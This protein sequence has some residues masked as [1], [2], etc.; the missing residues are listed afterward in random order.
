M[1]EPMI[2]KYY[3]GKYYT[4]KKNLTDEMMKK[5]TITEKPTR[6]RPKFMALKTH[7][8]FISM[9]KNVAIT[10]CVARSL[11]N[12][13]TLWKL[14]NVP[15]LRPTMSMQYALPP[16]R[17]DQVAIM[18]H[19]HDALMHPTSKHVF[20]LNM[21]TGFG[22][23]RIGVAMTMTLKLKTIIV[24]PTDAIAQQWIDDLKLVP[25]IR[26][27][28][29]HN[30]P[31]AGE[32]YND[33][34]VADLFDVIV[35]VINTFR[36]KDHKFSER[37]GFIIFDE[38]HE[39]HS[40][41]NVKALWN[42]GHKLALGLSASPEER[43]DGFDRA[44]FFHLGKPIDAKTI[45][46]FAAEESNFKVCV[47]AIKF[48]GKA[49]TQYT[50]SGMMS[51]PLTI[52]QLAMDDSRIDLIV[53]EIDR[54]QDMGVKGIFVFSELRSYL[55]KIKLRLPSAIL[56]DEAC[57]RIEPRAAIDPLS[58]LVLAPPILPMKNAQLD[59]E[60]GDPPPPPI[61]LLRG[62]IKSAE[63]RAAKDAGAH[64]VLTTY[65]YSR[66][67]VNLPTMTAIILATPRRNGMNQIIGRILR[68]GSDLSLM[69][70]VIDIVDVNVALA[71]Q[72]TT[73]KQF[74]KLRQ[75]PV[76]IVVDDGDH[77]EEEELSF[78]E[79]QELYIDLADDE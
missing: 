44:V 2:I 57:D 65:G 18:Q 1:A 13:P 28:Y 59:M 39:Y 46:G 21:Q 32:K 3:E 54:L 63:L 23:T 20:Y 61:S 38:A 14:T 33:L 75:Y 29:F 9:R 12:I 62:G 27:C 60:G 41:C 78:E 52:G 45:P 37:F 71:S 34:N 64:I 76:D 4:E 42:I 16:L 19:I 49:E 36:D 40:P 50:E 35:V 8:G 51:A 24:V 55:D 79:L 58:P 11:S 53:G 10:K 17:S 77:Y 56:E 22:K 31:P 25:G 48:N 26:Y 67:G 30:K 15:T 73:R 66:R 43:P 47:R 7:H 69:R 74:Y 72:F 70:H 6:N 5:L 68:R